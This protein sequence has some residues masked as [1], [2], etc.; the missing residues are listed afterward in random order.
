M[1]DYHLGQTAFKLTFLC[2]ELPSQLVAKWV[3]PDIWIP[4]QMVVWYVV[5]SAQYYLKGSKSFLLGRAL[6]GM[7]QGGFIPEVSIQSRTAG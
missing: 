7:L 5:G 4:T 6:L 2:A 1:S 3:G